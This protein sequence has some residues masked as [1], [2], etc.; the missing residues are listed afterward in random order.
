MSFGGMQIKE[1]DYTAFFESFNKSF[2]QFGE[3][4]QGAVKDAGKRTIQIKIE[5]SSNA[6]YKTDIGVV[7]GDITNEFPSETPKED[8]IY[9]KR[10]K[11]LVDE[12]LATRKEISLKVI[13]TIGTTVKGVI[14]PISVSNI[15][16][17]K[18]IEGLFQKKP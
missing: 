13:E 9:W 16:I 7:D 12:A 15:D 14:N 4:L 10:H 17:A 6:K 1:I 2:K 5:G 11:E 8:D 18:I 3:I